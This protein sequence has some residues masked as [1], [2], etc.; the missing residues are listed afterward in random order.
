M[1]SAAVED[2]AV[3]QSRFRVNEEGA[4]TNA[5]VERYALMLADGV[6]PNVAWRNVGYALETGYA[7][8]WRRRVDGSP[9]FKRRLAFLMAE[10]AETEASASPFAQARW[11][12][13]QL[14]REARAK[15][16][17][18][19]AEKA[20]DL[21]FKI[22]EREF[23]ISQASEKTIPASPAAPSSGPARGPGR[24]SNQQDSARPRSLT[25]LAGQFVRMGAE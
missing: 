17:I 23:A 16:D 9:V 21:L 24:P 1:G 14:W 13:S 22:G 10:K 19:A 8:D 20:A 2:R 5:K 18:R 12:A 3:Q 15:D 4:I 7:K 11:A 6:V 25:D